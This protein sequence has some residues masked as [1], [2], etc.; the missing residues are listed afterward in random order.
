M[1][2]TWNP[3]AWPPSPKDPHS[4]VCCRG[5]QI[6]T[7]SFSC[8]LFRKQTGV[9]IA[10]KSKFFSSINVFICASLFCFTWDFWWFSNRLQT[11]VSAGYCSLLN[12]GAASSLIALTVND[13]IKD[14]TESG[15]DP[16]HHSPRCWNEL[17]SLVWG[18]GASRVCFFLFFFIEISYTFNSHQSLSLMNILNIVYV[19][20]P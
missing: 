1:N 12:G 6:H 9:Q 2:E 15:Q 19:C 14:L 7:S 16:L 5:Y 8:E 4:A 18:E 13:S 10:A 11:P 3:S 20:Q 17:W